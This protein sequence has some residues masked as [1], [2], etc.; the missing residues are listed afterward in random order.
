MSKKKRLR[1]D[2]R[3]ERESA[4]N[5]LADLKDDA[6]DFFKTSSPF[7]ISFEL[8]KRGISTAHREGIFKLLDADFQKKWDPETPNELSEFKAEK[9]IA[10]VWKSE[11][12][13]KG[14]ALDADDLVFFMVGGLHFAMKWSES[15]LAM[16]E[17]RMAQLQTEIAHNKQALDS[18]PPEN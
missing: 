7:E 14:K 10:H 8:T 5:Y 2:S 13:A 18:L 16:S 15:R 6:L 17:T 11:A 12:L 9:I 4:E 3:Q 1:R